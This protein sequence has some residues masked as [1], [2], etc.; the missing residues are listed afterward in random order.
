MGEGK[1]ELSKERGEIKGGKRV[2]DPIKDQPIVHWLCL[3][4]PQGDCY[5]NKC[6]FSPFLSLYF[7]SLGVQLFV[8]LCE[9]RGHLGSQ[10]VPTML[11]LH[12][13]ARGGLELEVVFISASSELR[14]RHRL[15]GTPAFVS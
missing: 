12:C 11:P 14:H 15:Q 7:L 6:P 9:G 3:F 5:L 2:Q 1:R 4:S 8:S 13:V 10:P